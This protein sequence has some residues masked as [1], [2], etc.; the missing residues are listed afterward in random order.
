MLAWGITMFPKAY[1]FSDQPLS[2][3]PN[4]IDF[5]FCFHEVTEEIDEGELPLDY[6]YAFNISQFYSGKKY[7][8]LTIFTGTKKLDIFKFILI[9]PS[10]LILY[11]RNQVDYELMANINSIIFPLDGLLKSIDDAES[12][13]HCLIHHLLPQTLFVNSRITQRDLRMFERISS[14][15]L[16][17][18]VY[19]RKLIKQR[20]ISSLG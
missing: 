19:V 17:I 16:A 8:N 15:N 13:L 3:D 6:A 18:G 1:I 4:T 11:V 5:V 7:P 12:R 20:Y 10:A 14:N 9:D 2:V